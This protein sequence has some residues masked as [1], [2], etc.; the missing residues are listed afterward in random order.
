MALLDGDGVVSDS[1][2][3]VKFYAKQ[4]AKVEKVV[5]SDGTEWDTNDLQSVPFSSGRGSVRAD[6]YDGSLDGQANV[7]QGGKGSDVYILGGGSGNDTIDE[8]AYNTGGG[9]DVDVVRLASGITAS[10][11][12]LYRDSFN[13]L[14]SLS[15]A[16]GTVTDTLTV[17]NYYVND[18]AKIERVELSD[19]TKVWDTSDFTAAK[20]SSGYGSVG[21]DTYDGSRDNADGI[22]RGGR[23]SD[24]YILGGGSGNDTIDEAA[25]N[26]GGGNDVDVVRLKSGLTA[27]D[28]ELLRTRDHLIIR[29]L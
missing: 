17:K 23:G 20:L 6:T 16:S 2:R 4:T 26:I 13:L 24:V 22:L 3:V 11:V 29:V 21:A 5:F 8:A 10:Q 9:N 12:S 27:S 7:M 14:I 28:V 25:Y 15:D 18:A 1:L 19:G